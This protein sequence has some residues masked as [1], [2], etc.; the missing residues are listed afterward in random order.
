M[1]CLMLFSSNALAQ[2]EDFDSLVSQ[3]LTAPPENGWMWFQTPNALSAGMAYAEYQNQTGDTDNGMILLKDWIDP[4]IGM[5]HYR[6]KQTY[7]NVPV[8]G[9]GIVEHYNE[10]GLV[11]SNMK[12][13]IELDYD[14]KPT[15]SEDQALQSLLSNFNS[16][17]V[18]AWQDTD[19][20]LDYQYNTG[21]PNATNYPKG[22]LML[23]LGNYNDIDY[24]IPGNRYTL[25]YK[26][27]ILSLSPSS[28]LYYWVDANTGQV[29][30]DSPAEHFDGSAVVERH[31]NQ[32]NL[33]RIIDTRQRGFL[34]G[35]DWVLETD[36]AL[37]KIHTKY[38]DF[39]AWTLRPEI[40]DGDDIWAA[41][42]HATTGHWY[43]QRTWEYFRDVWDLAGV[44]DDNENVRLEVHSN[45]NGN[46]SIIK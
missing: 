45:L 25:A 35:N 43:V 34:N 32:T 10:T 14:V 37:L 16:N 39:A 12:L 21:D 26:F 42:V 8:E 11:F 9:T 31:S 38:Y 33:S 36:G 1:I 29:L 19:W 13:A 41:D 4:H 30:R 5:H 2:L 20:E 3:Y 28:H 18:F 40:E 7:K 24:I 6:Y 44:D 46:N 27:E 23:A 17:T 15:L 22:E